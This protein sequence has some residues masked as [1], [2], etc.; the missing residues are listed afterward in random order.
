MRLE[1]FTASDQV[2]RMPD[3]S[4]GNRLFTSQL[5]K[6]TG[7][8]EQIAEPTKRRTGMQPYLTSQVAIRFACWIKN[9]TGKV[10]LRKDDVQHFFKCRRLE[11]QADLATG[12]GPSAAATRSAG[13]PGP[14]YRETLQ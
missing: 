11:V 5:C 4:G 2:K 10:E 13:C 1:V 8:R 3:S 7:E 12:A 6:V 9:P 14:G